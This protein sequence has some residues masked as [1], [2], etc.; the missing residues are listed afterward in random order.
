MISFPRKPSQHI[1]KCHW[2]NSLRSTIR[3][4]SPDLRFLGAGWKASNYMNAL[5][6]DSQNY[7]LVRVRILPGSY[8]SC[9]WPWNWSSGSSTSIGWREWWSGWVWETVIRLGE[10]S[11]PART[12]HRRYVSRVSC[13]T[14]RY[15]RQQIPGWSILKYHALLVGESID[16]T[17]YRSRSSSI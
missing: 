4:S 9:L 15:L 10:S 2:S 16:R 13:N 17:V 14:R 11:Y 12:G 1:E 6:H 8:W 7:E 3:T 5:P